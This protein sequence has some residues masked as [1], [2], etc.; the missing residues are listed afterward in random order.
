MIPRLAL[1]L[2]LR[3]HCL[4]YSV[5]VLQA[6]VSSID[7]DLSAAGIP[8]Q[9]SVETKWRTASDVGAFLI[10]TPKIIREDFNDGFNAPYKEWIEDNFDTLLTHGKVEMQRFGLW[11]ITETYSTKACM[12]QTWTDKTRE[13]RVALEA[14]AMMAG[15]LGPSI[16]R[17]R[18]RNCEALSAYVNEDYGGRVVL[19][20]N[21]LRYRFAHRWQGI[22]RVVSELGMIIVLAQSDFTF[23]PYAQRSHEKK[24]MDAYER[25]AH[26]EVEE[27]SS[28]AV[29]IIHAQNGTEY[30]MTSGSIGH[31][32]YSEEDDRY[33]DG[34]NDS[35]DKAV[36]T[37]LP[38][39][40]P[41]PTI[42][43]RQDSDVTCDSCDKHACI[44][45]YHCKTC[46]DFDLCEECYVDRRK[47]CDADANHRFDKIWWFN[48]REVLLT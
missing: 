4:L 26:S 33:F 31:Q 6:H 19:F 18:T 44:K 9:F 30:E 27:K 23:K 7:S 11:M 1:T 17:S 15:Q 10:T 34:D 21:G 2:E 16:E 3:E 12:I 48:G 41:S 40:D 46:S 13:V 35:E 43:Y 36:D 39:R 5:Q 32:S 42:S 14:N 24:M 38:Y 47:T 29:D 28:S 20:C 45:Y 25:R 8:A 22:K 37:R